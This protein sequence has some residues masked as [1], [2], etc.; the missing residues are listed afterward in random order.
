MDTGVSATSPCAAPCVPAH[1][2]CIPAPHACPHSAGCVTPAG[3][4]PGGACACPTPAR[5]HQSGG[6]PHTPR[7]S[8]GSIS[9]TGEHRTHG[10]GGAGKGRRPSLA[11]EVR[12][13]SRPGFPSVPAVLRPG[14]H[15]RGSRRH[16]SGFSLKGEQS[17]VLARRAGEQ[18]ATGRGTRK[19][20]PCGNST[21]VGK[22]GHFPGTF[23]SPSVP[24]KIL[25]HPR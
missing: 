14:G 23:V 18:R 16:L 1:A 2:C 20:H 8:L 7:P 17:P 5:V 22:R 21:S 9:P 15:R 11:A 13:A 3:R 6:C 19:T 4:H 12:D 24:P 10:Q 25:A